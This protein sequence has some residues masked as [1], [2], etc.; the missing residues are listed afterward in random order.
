MGNSALRWQR[1]VFK[2]RAEAQG[3]PR[4]HVAAT[5][6]PET[7]HMELPRAQAGG[8]AGNP[9]AQVAELLSVP[10]VAEP[11]TPQAQVAE[12]PSVPPVAEP[13]TPQAQVAELPSVPPVAEPLK[14]SPEQ[15]AAIACAA[16][17]TCWPCSGTGSPG[18]ESTFHPA[19]RTMHGWTADGSRWQLPH[20]QA[21]V[22]HIHLILWK[23]GEPRAEVVT[24]SDGSGRRYHIQFDGQ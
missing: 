5:V 24:E 19:P 11:E 2:S 23:A 20:G 13:E 12:L 22:R 17:P 15:V 7:E 1:V 18:Q 14:V 16:I 3:S 4:G 8:T 21:R 10:P 9:Q 6:P